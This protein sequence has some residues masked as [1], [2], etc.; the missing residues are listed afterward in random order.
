MRE[1]THLGILG[2][3]RISRITIDLGQAVQE[4]GY[5]PLQSFWIQIFVKEGVL[6]IR[7]EH[8]ERNGG[9]VE[10]PYR[11]FKSMADSDTFSHN[12]THWAETCGF[13]TQRSMIRFVLE[14]VYEVLT[15]MQDV[16][17]R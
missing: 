8:D 11:D 5:R 1:R 13:P 4:E 16:A 3:K 14:C 17:P 7:V 2:G 12:F 10:G 9:G 6:H 15:T